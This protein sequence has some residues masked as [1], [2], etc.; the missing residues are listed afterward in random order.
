MLSRFAPFLGSGFFGGYSA[1]RAGGG[2]GRARGRGK[3]ECLLLAI[4]ARGR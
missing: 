1:C 3:I 2:A 4:P